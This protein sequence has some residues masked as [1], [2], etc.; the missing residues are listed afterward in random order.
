M[1]SSDLTMVYGKDGRLGVI[2]SA[3]LPI[4]DRRSHVLVRLDN[5]Q[6]IW[7]PAELLQHRT[8]GNYTLPV[9]VDQI[10]WESFAARDEAQPEAQAAPVLVVPVIEEQLD[11]STRQM[12]RSL[13]LTKRV[14]EREEL[15]D[16]PGFVE[17]LEVE[18]I[19]QNQVLDGPVSIRQEGDTLIVPL[20]E[21]M[22]VVE[23][24]LVLKEEVRVTRKRRQVRNP[25]RVTLR[26][27]EVVVERSEGQKDE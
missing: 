13:T 8:D 1:Q 27:E 12:T 9:S 10:N 16:E 4:D 3:S 7:V 23:K 2:D 21:E 5:G 17:E 11:V 20:V 25:Q 22:L 14:Q 18:R 6:R 24:R 15:V 26:R 19:P